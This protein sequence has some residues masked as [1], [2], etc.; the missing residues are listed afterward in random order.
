[1]KA[2]RVEQF[3]DPDVMK[4]IDVP[5]LQAGRGQLLVRMHAIGVNPVEAYIRA[6]TYPRK[7]GLPFTPGERRGR[8]D[9]KCG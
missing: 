3:G 5:Q 9:R 1:M 8:R 2:I 4:A 7:P 6:G